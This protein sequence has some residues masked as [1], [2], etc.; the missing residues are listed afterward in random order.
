MNWQE[1][2][3]E[4]INIDKLDE[5]IDLI[6]N[7]SNFY[8]NSNKTIE[9]RKLEHNRT[10]GIVYDFK[11]EKMYAVILGEEVV[12]VGKPFLLSSLKSQKLK[13]DLEKR[14]D[15]SFTFFDYQFVLYLV[16]SSDISSGQTWFKNSIQ[17]ILNSL[18]IGKAI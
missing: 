1:L 11:S 16:V 10:E 12:S 18:K 2:Y 14:V 6:E 17:E 4:L 9:I 13:L 3:E 7:D 5:A 8:L 15:Y